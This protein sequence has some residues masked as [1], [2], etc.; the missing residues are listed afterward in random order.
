[1]TLFRNHN[2]ICLVDQ[3]K[4]EPYERFIERGNF[5]AC[6]KPQTKEEYDK[7]VLYS[8]IYINSKYFGCKYDGIVT[9]ELN[10]MIEKLTS[11]E[12]GVV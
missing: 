9:S 8:R 10:K 3:E 12:P 4:L 7:V 6:Q 2:Y 1:M 5:I 11:K